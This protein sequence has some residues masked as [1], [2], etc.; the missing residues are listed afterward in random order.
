MKYLT[1]RDK[2]GMIRDGLAVVAVIVAFL[3]LH[4]TGPT[5]PPVVEV[6][7][8]TPA[9]TATPV[10]AADTGWH[11]ATDPYGA[12]YRIDLPYAEMNDSQRN[13]ADRFSHTYPGGQ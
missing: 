9:P 6:V 1:N 12:T 7:V 2:N 10:P 8:P 5:K 3:V 4:D 13:D 11:L